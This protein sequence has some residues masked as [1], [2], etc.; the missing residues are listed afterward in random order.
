[1]EVDVAVRREPRMV[2]VELGEILKK[3]LT[4]LDHYLSIGSVGKR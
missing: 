3:S 2:E 1:M 4:G